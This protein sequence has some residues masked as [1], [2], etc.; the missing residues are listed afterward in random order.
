MNKELKDNIISNIISIGYYWISDENP[1]CSINIYKLLNKLNTLTKSQRKKIDDFYHDWNALFKVKYN[2]KEFELINIPNN[3]SSNDDLKLLWISSQTIMN[4][5]AST[6][7]EMGY[8]FLLEMSQ[9]W[10]ELYINVIE[11]IKKSKFKL[12]FSEWLIMHF[13]V[14]LDINGTKDMELA[15]YKITKLEEGGFNE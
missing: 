14:A 5:I 8:M 10:N 6:N 12:P 7:Y 13:L 11:L 3:Y 4:L 9:D 15:G 1:Q 2:E